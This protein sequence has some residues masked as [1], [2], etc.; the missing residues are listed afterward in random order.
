MPSKEDASRDTIF[1]GEIKQNKSFEALLLNHYDGKMQT[2]WLKSLPANDRI[3]I[4]LEHLAPKKIE[5]VKNK[6][7]AKLTMMMN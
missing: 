5:N 2:E 7:K 1:N 4:C 3:L 6:K